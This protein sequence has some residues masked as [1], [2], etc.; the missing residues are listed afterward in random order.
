MDELKRSR[1]GPILSLGR[2]IDEYNSRSGGCLLAGVVAKLERVA[3]V[4]GDIGTRCSSPLATHGFTTLVAGLRVERMAAPLV[5]DGPMRSK[6][7]AP[8]QEAVRTAIGQIVEVIEPRKCRNSI[9]NCGWKGVSVDM[10]SRPRRACY[11]FSER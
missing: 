6:A 11:P 7:A 8:T 1:A 2:F 4:D 3:G 5:I 10:P 9:R